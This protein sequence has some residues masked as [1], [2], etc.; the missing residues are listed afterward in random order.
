MGCCACA[1]GPGTSIGQHLACT[2][3][4]RAYVPCAMVRQTWPAPV[5]SVR[6]GSVWP[7]PCGQPDTRCSGPTS[8]REPVHPSCRS[9]LTWQPL[10]WSPT[11]ALAGPEQPGERWRSGGTA[12]VCAAGGQGPLP[13]LQAHRQAQAGRRERHLQAG[14]ARGECR[15]RGRVACGSMPLHGTGRQQRLF[16]QSSPPSLHYLPT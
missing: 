13:V 11:Y 14:A 6:A 2:I 8:I 1:K 4:H 5:R 16:R 7:G 15:A 12:D 9:A 10:V 3:C